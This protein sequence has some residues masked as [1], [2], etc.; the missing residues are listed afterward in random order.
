M[1]RGFRLAVVLLAGAGMF[2][3]PSVAQTGNAIVKGTVL[4]PGG[5]S[6][7]KAKVVL[8]NEDTGIQRTTE[9]AGTGDYYFGGVPPGRYRVNIEAEGFKKWSGTL[10]VQVGDQ[11]TVN[12]RLEIGSLETVVE[13]SGAAPAITTTSAEIGDVKDALRIQQLPLNGRDITNLFNLTPGVE[14][15]GGGPRVNGLKV[16]SLEMLVDGISIVDRFGGGVSRVRPGLDTIQEFRIETAGSN[17]RYSR[18]GT[19]TMVTKSGT[20]DL[21]GSLFETHRNNSAGLRARQRQEGNTSSKLI[22]N[23]FGASA[24]GPVI[25]PGLYDGRNR[26]FW[27][28]AW[29]GS[30]QR[31]L[32]FQ[33]DN[34]PTAEMWDGNL[35]QIIDNAGFQTHIFD[36]LTTDER[37]VRQQFA[38]NIIPR[39]RLHQFFGTM[40]S[41]T[42]APTNPNNPFRDVNF[43]FFYPNVVDTDSYTAR[44][45]HRFSDKDNVFGRYTHSRRYNELAGGRF[46]SP[47]PGQLAF[48]TGRS[49]SK[50]Y[51]AAITW[52]RTFTPTFLNE[53]LVA[54]NRSPHSNGTLADFEPW[55]DKLGLPNPFGLTGWP[56]I[57]ASGPFG[58]DADNRHNQHLTA[59]VV[60]DNVTR[61]AGTHNLTFGVK[62]RREENNVRE[63][64]QA[65]GS[66]T[67]GNAW[68]AQYDPAANQAVSRTGTGLASM[69]LGLPTFLSNQFNRGYFYFQQK[70]IGLYF[71]DNWRVSRR[72]TL[73]LGVRWDKWTPYREKLNRL[74]NVDLETALSRFEVLT[75][76]SHRMEELRGVPPSVLASWARRGLSW[77][78]ADEAGFPSSLVAADNNNFGPRIGAAFRVTENTVIRAGYGEYFWTM[79]LSQILQS[80][81]SNPPLNLRYTNP[82]GTF[83]TTSTF[84]VRTAPRPEFF[85]GRAQVDTAGIVLL[86]NTAQAITVLDAKDWKDGRAQSWHFTIEREIMPNT[87]LRLSYIGDHGRDME[88]HLALNSV[89]TEF[90]YQTRTGN[91]IPGVTDLR[92]ANPNWNFRTINRTGYSNTHSLQAEVERRYSNGLAFQWFYTFTRSL[93]TT[94][95]GGFTAGNGAIN[96]T[97]G[98]G[99][100]PENIQILGAPNL[101]Y[102]ERQRLIY[103]NSTQVPAQRV[104]WNAIWDLP[105]GKGRK[106]G[107]NATG[108]LNHLIGGWQLATLGEWRS[109]NWLS[110]GTGGYLFG[111]PTLS[112]D[113]RLLLTFNNRPQRLWFRGDFDPTRATNIDQQKLQALVP[114]NRAD[115]VFRPAGPN[116][117]NRIPMTLRNGTVRATTITD[118]VNW[119]ARAFFRG[120]GAWNADASL[121]KNFSLTE[122]VGLRFT[123]DFFNVLNHPLD[124]NPNA[125][126][127]LQDLSVQ[128]NDPRIIQFSLRLSF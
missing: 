19:V 96:S 118:N 98:V 117:D 52:N 3:T 28:F 80:S 116:F 102:E 88:Q 32:Q 107:G 54:V 92:R 70:E 89:E 23:E 59:F 75:P 110:V 100:V 93:T 11:A 1:A 56:T 114:A 25:L 46:G 42:A 106:L 112:D 9:S 5:A 47:T 21:H 33:R 39:S 95:A 13:I 74:V 83:D 69:A 86:P 123:A 111:D 76:D 37:G 57:S 16:G 103:Y 31:S 49:D 50:V 73:D 8:V 26:S 36:P 38:G 122:R 113:Q 84:A 15:G 2:V 120:P 64:Q 43:E 48:G 27:F 10:V 81:R 12:A 66:H 65:Q 115:R 55:A 90:N 7:P 30:R 108:L 24:G 99:Q 35:N 34:V 94:D 22:R 68:T 44:L 62:L 58:W 101:S 128:P 85:I 41:V 61:I 97:S 82:I 14:G 121:F 105:F 40:H 63:L 67:F 126:T 4:D 127:G 6:I 45:D 53:L 72:L 77:R 119:N 79:P 78:T 125:T 91:A 60:E 71:H 87:G 20:N 51:N 124:V 17:A 18:P 104:R 109:G 29:E